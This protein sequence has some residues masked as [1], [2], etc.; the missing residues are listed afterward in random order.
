MYAERMKTVQPTGGTLIINP[1]NPTRTRKLAH[2]P[3][4]DHAAGWV[5]YAFA[6]AA[7]GAYAFY[8]DFELKD[9]SR[10]IYLVDFRSDDSFVAEFTSLFYNWRNPDGLSGYIGQLYNYNLRPRTFLS[11]PLSEFSAWLAAH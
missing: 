7:S 2:D 6:V 10:W 9:G 1:P 5:D 4:H 11:M 3:W 8:F